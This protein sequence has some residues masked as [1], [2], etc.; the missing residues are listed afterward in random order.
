MVPPFL[1]LVLVYRGE[2]ERDILAWLLGS[3]FFGSGLLL[4]IW[5]QMHLHYRLR[6]HKKLTT[7]GPYSIV[8]NPIYIANTAILIGLTFMSELLWFLPLMLAW[9]GLV[10]SLVVRR[11][12]AHLLQKYGTPYQEFLSSVPRWC[13]RSMTFSPA[14][15]STRQFLWRSIGAELHC[16]LWLLPVFA[17]QILPY[18][19]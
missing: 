15:E 5:A 6:E 7:S 19:A 16:F 10:Y 17:K 12:E 14:G 2:T 18:L 8:R 1:V 9:C 3:V 11:E 13:P 4:R